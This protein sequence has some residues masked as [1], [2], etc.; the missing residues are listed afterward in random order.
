MQ[1]LLAANPDSDELLARLNAIAR[2]CGSNVPDFF[3]AVAL[4]TDTDT[5]DGRC[6]KV[7]LMTMHAAKGLEFPVVFITGC[8]MDYLPFKRSEAHTPDVAEERRLFYVA[9]TRAKEE[10]VLTYT[11]K[12]FLYGKSVDRAISPFVSDIEDRLKTLTR[13]R[14]RKQP[15]SRQAQLKLFG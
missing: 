13:T 12:R 14:A 1:R 7:A 9:M 11:R 3:K 6:E 8:E 5:Y 4:Q 15:G 10:L 2:Q